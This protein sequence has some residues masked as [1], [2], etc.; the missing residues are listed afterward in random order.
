MNLP[1]HVLRPVA[2]PLAAVL[3]ALLPTLARAQGP[4][5]PLG[6]DPSEASWAVGVAA[7]TDFKP[8]RGVERRTR[9][10]PLLAFENRWVRVLGP[11]L[12]FKLGRS[13][14]LSYGLTLAYA[15]DGYEADDSPALAGMAERKAGAWLG[16]RASWQADWA[17]LSADWSADVS[18][19]S[20]GQKLRLGVER[21]VQMGPLGLTPRVTA[22]WLDSKQVAYYY[23]V[24][25]AEVRADRAAY[26]PGSTVNTEIGLRMDYGLAP[27]QTLFADVGLVSLGSAIQDSPLVD[28]RRLPEVR[29]GYL[30]RF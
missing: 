21:R 18:G 28:R 14:P 29:L 15:G 13:G 12:E 10:W 11:G 27:Q 22:T 6:A 16:G 3:V 7:F 17:R 25:A 4:M 2:L 19:H 8:Y 9:V 23:G 5:G 1:L 30:Y 20:K 26:R 24:D